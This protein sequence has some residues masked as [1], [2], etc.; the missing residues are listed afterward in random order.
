MLFNEPVDVSQLS[1]LQRLSLANQAKKSSSGASSLA[2]FARKP[3]S[4]PT[5]ANLGP[6]AAATKPS[7]L[8]ALAIKRRSSDAARNATISSLEASTVH[9][10]G[11][12]PSSNLKSS[13]LARKIK[14]AHSMSETPY[15]VAEVNSVNKGF[16]TQHPSLGPPP[17]QGEVDSMNALFHTRSSASAASATH[18]A[19]LTAFAHP[20][21]FGSL[22]VA[23]W[24]TP[25]SK[26]FI[27]PIHTSRSNVQFLFDSPSPDD[28]VEAKR[29]GTRLAKVAKERERH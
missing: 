15:N 10:E 9:V 16:Q 4:Q 3:G 14:L 26:Q 8:V 23:G 11:D 17:N 7:S 24:H 29:V 6:R 1:A 22:L 28:L 2:S 18:P 19:L 13:K 27:P 12:S 25:V 20:S 5:L 21:S